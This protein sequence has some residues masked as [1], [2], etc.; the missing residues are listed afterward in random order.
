VNSAEG[1]S[2]VCVCGLRNERAIES[3]SPALE[4]PLSCKQTEC[5]TKLLRCLAATMIRL[6]CSSNLIN[7]YHMVTRTLGYACT[8]MVLLAGCGFESAGPREFSLIRLQMGDRLVY[9]D[10]QG[11]TLKVIS[12]IAAIGDMDSS[13]ALEDQGNRELTFV[14]LEGN[15][16]Y[17]YFPVLGSGDEPDIT[18]GFWLRIPTPEDSIQHGD[19]TDQARNGDSLSTVVRRVKVSPISK[20]ECYFNGY[21][22][23]TTKVL[24]EFESEFCYHCKYPTF[25]REKKE[26]VYFDSLGIEYTSASVFEN[27]KGQ[28]DSLTQIISK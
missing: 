23:T 18:H 16:I 12:T 24:L 1:Y 21:W 19:A 27:S 25:I 4:I 17:R 3:R 20:G 10:G 6:K 15:K 14:K 8:I 9:N 5:L 2:R 22:Y 13:I 26:R 28:S 7:N 11:R